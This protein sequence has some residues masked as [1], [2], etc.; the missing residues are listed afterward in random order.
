MQLES[1]LLYVAAA[2]NILL[3]L[4]VLS[5][6]YKK[7]YGWYFAITMLGVAVWAIGD[8]LV[9]SIAPTTAFADL[10]QRVFYVSPMVIPVSILFFALTYPDRRIEHKFAIGS[11]AVMLLCA[12]PIALF[13]HLVLRSVHASGDLYVPKP[14]TFGFILY[15]LYFSAIFLAVYVALFFSYKQEH[16]TLAKVQLRY[17]LI[18]TIVSSIPALLTNLSLPLMGV[19]DLIWL[20][21]LFTTIF[22]GTIGLSIIQHRMFDIRLVIA[23][24]LGYVLSLGL[25]ALI[26]GFVVFGF[27]RLILGLH[28]S[29]ASQIFLSAAT[30]VTALSFGRIKR[31]FDRITNRL[32]YRDAYDAQDLYDHLNRVLV[33]TLNTDKLLREV[34]NLLQDSFKAE[35]VVIGLKGDEKNGNRVFG[36]QPGQSFDDVVP[37]LR[38]LTVKHHQ[39]IIPTDY[40]EG[41][42]IHLKKILD[43]KNVAVLIRLTPNVRDEDAGFGY[44]A[45]GRKKSGNLYSTSDFRVLDTIA[46]ELII[47]IQNALHFEEIQTFND[48]LRGRVTQ[49]TAELRRT[50]EKLKTLD[51]TKD[52]FISMA[53]HQLRTPLTSVKGYLSM[54]LEGDAGKLNAQQKQLLTQSFISSQR[55]V[56]L[57]ADLLNLSRL[58]TGKFVI[59]ATPL[60]LREVVQGEIDQLRETAKSRGLTL[61]YDSPATFPLLMLDETKIHQVVMNFI[62]NA[63]YYTPSGG[64][65]TITLLETPSA[66]EY[67][68]TDNGIGVPK[69]EQHRLFTKFYRAGNARRARPD[70]TGLGLFMAKKVVV[71]QGGAVIF[72]SEE[73]KGSVFGF[74]F[75]KAHH[76]APGSEDGIKK[77]T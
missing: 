26:Y 4:L 7:P 46:N 69:T 47:A 60:D 34:S 27:A 38:P 12:I 19:G 35:F 22:V 77:P 71:A 62:D 72:S 74:R 10:W 43:D 42:D 66:V 20:G 41:N 50:N 25:M 21:P 29:I 14:E 32:F 30:S 57:I 39:T 37:A 17:T 59:E 51:E 68:V 24:S 76:L 63:I 2:T 40:L 56:Y 8:S 70:G 3:G 61:V 58:N 45:F 53:S 11:V 33:S 36:A 9:L 28:F 15:A 54:V 5:R 48:T 31:M 44:L 49:A 67:R 23:R 6:T 16:N 73:G 55:M 65:I 52:E 75:T 64:T 13:P 18:G 1:I